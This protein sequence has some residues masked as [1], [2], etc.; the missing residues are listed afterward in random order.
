M[1]CVTLVGM[2]KR[3]RRP[4]KLEL[5]DGDRDA[6]ERLVNHPTGQN[7]DAR[8]ARIVLL[9][10]EGLGTADI[11]KTVGL[12]T[13][14]VTRWKKRYR[15]GGFHALTDAPR[16][17]RPR[18]VTDE[19]VQQVVE[20]TLE[21][22]PKGATHWATRGLAKKVGISRSSVSRIWQ[23]FRLKPHRQDTF[24]LSNDPHLVDKVHDVVGLYLNPPANAVVLSVD[25]KTQIQA[26]ERTQTVLPLSTGL[27]KAISPKYKRH[28]TVDFFA[29]L[30]IV[31]GRLIGKT[32]KAHKS[33][34]FID[35]LAHID[36]EIDAELDVHIIVDN[37]SIHRSAET[38]E[39]L[40]RHPRF[41]M[42]Y[43][44]T[45]CSWLN[46][47]EA[48]FALLTARQLKHGV[49]TSVRQLTAAINEFV[50][51]H[52]DDPQPFIWTR[53]AEQI[54]DSLGRFCAGVLDRHASD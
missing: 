19:L 52:N 44:P 48:I 17:G 35:F 33:A 1:T 24:E 43:T 32:Y 39:W 38:L 23:A 10:S 40:S 16:S 18:T 51:A 47:V 29:A 7:R 49:H 54:I 6:L 41:H 12:G 4:A 11:A 28:G 42:H 8:R 36:R 15:E 21:S 20:L 50:E 14:T 5:R 27:I 26:L 45:Y 25:Q 2:A 53:T 37:H 13:S 34:D 30:D 9:A 22:K 46:Q 31:T 3:G